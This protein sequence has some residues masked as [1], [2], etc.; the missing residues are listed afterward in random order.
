MSIKMTPTKLRTIIR[1]EYVNA[2]SENDSSEMSREGVE[3]MK[4]VAFQIAK[5][6]ARE[7]DTTSMSR[8]LDKVRLLAAVID[9]VKLHMKE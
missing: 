9:Q 1:E 4:D 3:M 5:K 6:L 2:L 7:I 8:S